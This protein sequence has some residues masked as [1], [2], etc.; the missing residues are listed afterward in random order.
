MPG[1]VVRA[2]RMRNRTAVAPHGEHA[3]LHA[4]SRTL[5]QPPPPPPAPGGRVGGQ[6]ASG[7]APDAHRGAA[8]ES[9]AR[10]PRASRHP[11]L[12]RAA[13]E[14]PAYHARTAPA[15]GVGGRHHLSGRRRRVA[16]SR[17]R[18]GSLLPPNPGVDAPAAARCQRHP[19]RATTPIWHRSFTRSRRKSCEGPPSPPMR[20]GAARFGTSSVTTITHACIQRLAFRRRLTTKPAW[21][22]SPAGVNELGGRSQPSYRMRAPRAL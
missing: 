16:L 13:S 2:A 12:L 1:V 4:S 8:R 7:G 5:R 17:R 15:S 21:H 3:P 14:S 11:P 18:H 10:L 22:N 20:L 6:P 9:R 19:G